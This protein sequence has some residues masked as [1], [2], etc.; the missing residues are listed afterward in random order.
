MF[1]CRLFHRDRP[2]EQVE[3][4]LLSDGAIT[5]GRDPGADWPLPDPDIALSRHH[6]TLSVEEDRLFLRDTST[7]GTLVDGAAITRDTPVELRS[8]QTI[9]LG[10]LIIVIDQPA[11]DEVVGAATTILG[12]LEIGHTPVLEQWTDGAQPS[13]SYS[14]DSLLDAFCEG[15]GL[16]VSALS[17]EEPYQ[18][19]RRAGAIYKQ[20]ILGLAALMSDRAHM[21]SQTDL[22]R[23]TI[24]AASNNPIK[25]T[26]SRRLGQALLS[27]PSTGFLGGEDAVR[28]A[29]GDL[30]RHMTG[31]AEGA[32][33][34]ANFTVA[35][36]APDAVEAEAREQRGLLR[37]HQT[38]RWDAYV[39]RYNTLVANGGDNALRRIFV[40]TYVRAVEDSN[41]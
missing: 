13:T 18:V 40:E 7:N 2:F 10:A 38:L 4:R 11:A 34:A 21:K 24:A 31:L 22:E 17:G 5:V 37:N 8:R 36:L 28:A 39:K 12:G 35:S 25:W 26:P 15:A 27:P 41:P 29:F 32:N 9:G 14:E 1:V 3:A 16:D 20:A 23:T 33:A 30:G 19:M 6:C